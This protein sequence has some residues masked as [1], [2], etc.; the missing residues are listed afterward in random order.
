MLHEAPQLIVDTGVRKWHQKIAIFNQN[1]TTLFAF[2]QNV[3][4]TPTV[5]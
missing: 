4:G 2:L 5:L 1:E 3:F